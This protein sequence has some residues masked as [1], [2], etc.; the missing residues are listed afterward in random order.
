MSIVSP[1]GCSGKF[2]APTVGG[3]EW[4]AWGAL[5][6]LLERAWEG[7]GVSGMGLHLPELG[8]GLYGDGLLFFRLILL[9]YFVQHLSGVSHGFLT[10]LKL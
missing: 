4:T 2:L 7:L 3:L 9:Q 10:D 5:S 1:S 8:P 6:P